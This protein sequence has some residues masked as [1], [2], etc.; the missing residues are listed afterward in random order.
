MEFQSTFAVT[1]DGLL[2]YDFSDLEIW[3]NGLHCH[4]TQKDKYEEGQEKLL[5]RINAI[6]SSALSSSLSPDN[7][8]QILSLSPTATPLLPAIPNLDSIFKLPTQYV[9]TIG[10][11]TDVFIHA[12]T[13]TLPASEVLQPVESQLSSN[14]QE[15]NDSGIVGIGRKED[16]EEERS[17]YSYE[18]IPRSINDWTIPVDAVYVG[19]LPTYISVVI[20][21][22][23]MV[24]VKT[25]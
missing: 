16:E 21:C 25:V 13:T 10:D 19:I 4:N 14:R 24:Y 1:P 2:F 8:N 23:S 12:P 3:D 17:T 20:N 5:G 9:T 7:N 6:L 22:I 15:E 11:S 18:Y